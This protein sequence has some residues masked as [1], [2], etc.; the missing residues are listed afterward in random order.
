MAGR[1]CMDQ[2][3]VDVTDIPGVRTGMTATLIGR[4]GEEE[5]SAP[6]AAAGAE[7]ITNELLSR[8]GRRLKTVR[9]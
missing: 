4:D 1:I 2:M 3:A 5:I 8:M 9:A 6:E 7:S